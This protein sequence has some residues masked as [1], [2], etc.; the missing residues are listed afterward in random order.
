M[1]DHHMD[2][3]DSAKTA[4]LQMG[5]RFE[6]KEGMPYRTDEEIL[7][8]RNSYGDD[9]DQTILADTKFNKHI[10]QSWARQDAVAKLAKSPRDLIGPMRFG[11]DRPEG[12]QL[13]SRDPEK[14]GLWRVTRFDETMD[15]IGHFT[16][17]FPQ[18]VDMASHDGDIT[19]FRE[20]NASEAMR[21][22]SKKRAV[23]WP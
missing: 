20:I 3:V 11:K 15:P 22:T 23:D 5:V 12:T 6:L 2:P 8:G 1:R 10:L 14:T 4:A 17:T 9:I 21:K 16:G 7:A 13:I 18:V 19:R